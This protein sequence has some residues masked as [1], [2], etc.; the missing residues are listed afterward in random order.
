MLL[1]L[2]VLAMNSLFLAVE[3]CVI[4]SST[5]EA[6]RGCTCVVGCL[7]FHACCVSKFRFVN[8]FAGFALHVHLALGLAEVV[9]QA[10]AAT[11]IGVDAEVG[12]EVGVGAEVLFC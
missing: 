3:F 12:V 7:I 10:E 2:T 9:T 11:E 4:V 6:H 5:S 8:G 1:A